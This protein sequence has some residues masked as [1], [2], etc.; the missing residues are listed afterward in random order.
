MTDNAVVSIG[1]YRIETIIDGGDRSVCGTH[2]YALIN[3]QQARCTIVHNAEFDDDIALKMAK[4]E[5]I[6]YFRDYFRDN[7]LMLTSTVD[8][9]ESPPLSLEAVEWAWQNLGKLDKPT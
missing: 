5:F 7:P 1:I 9:I 2:F 8:N 6:D 4:R 3:G